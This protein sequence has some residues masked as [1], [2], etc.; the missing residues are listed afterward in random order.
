MKR[1]T[2]ILYCELGDPNADT[3]PEDLAQL[4]K[5]YGLTIV[6]ERR[7]QV[8]VEASGEEIEKLKREHPRVAITKR[9]QYHRAV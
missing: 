1:E 9:K 8:T 7:A 2:Y 4:A 5:Q 6:K 3:D